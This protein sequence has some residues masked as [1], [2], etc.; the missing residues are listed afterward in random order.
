M[1][2]YKDLISFEPIE[3]VIQLREANNKEKA[4]SLLESYVISD[5]M[6]NRI[7]EDIFENL[8]FDRLVDNRGLL[9]VGNYGSG[10]SHLMSVVSTIAELPGSSKHLRHDEVAKK[11]EEV[12]GKFNV[13][14]AEFGAVTMPLRDIIC[15]HLERGLDKMGVEYIFPPSDQVTN[16]KDMLYEMMELFQ[17][18]YPEQGLLLVIDELLDYLRGRN[19]MQLTLDLGFL[20]ELGEVCSNSRFRFISGVQ[21]M[22]FDN[23]KFSFVAESLRRVKERFKETR[24]IREDIAFVVSERL[25]HKNEEQKAIIRDHLNKFTKMYNGLSEELDRY[26]DI[27]PIHP[28]YLEIFERVNI[29][30][31]RVALKTISEEIKK[32]ID[33]E[34]P[35]NETGFVSFDNY[36]E[37]I[38]EDA[39]LRSNDRVKVVMDKVTT[40]KGTIQ[41]SMKPVYKPM[42]EKMVNALAVFRLTTE[43]LNTPIG[44]SSEAMRDQL[45]ISN[46]SLL[47]LDD[48]IADFLKTTIDAAMKDL[49]NAASFQFISVNEAN[50]QYYINIDEAIPVD[51]LIN[52]RGDML[53]NAT[54]DSYYFDVLKN[55]TEVSDNTYVQGYKIWLH[56]I[57]W[58]DH[59]VKRQGYLFFGAPNER[60]TAQPERDFYIF[61]LQAFEEPKYKD[62]EREDEVFFRL[63]N[64][65]DKFVQLLRQYGGAVELYH[66]TTTNKSLYRPKITQYQK[67][68]LKWI[69]ERFADSFEVVYGGR[70]SM[71]ME[72][73]ALLHGDTDT[74]VDLID[75]VSQDLL[76]QWFGK[77]YPDYPRFGK[78]DRSYL[79]NSNLDIYAK[80]AL[81]YLNGKKTAQGEA[82]LNG[83]VLLDQQNK[84]AVQ[85]SGYAKWILDVLNK[86]TSTQVVNQN[87]LI[88]TINTVQG[89]VDQR[90]TKEFYLEPELLAVL[91]GALIHAGEI[92]VN[93]NGNTYDA[94]SYSEFSKLSVKDITHFNHIKK[95]TGLPIPEM[96]AL[97]EM[98]D[99]L[100]ADFSDS[101]QVDIMIANIISKAREKTKQV[102]ELLANLEE[103]L[104]KWDGPLYTDEELDDYVVQ[105]SSLN[106]FLQ[107]LQVYNTKAK[108]KNLK[109]TIERIEKEKEHLL[110]IDEIEQIHKK[111]IDYSKLADYLTKAQ[112]II[113]PDDKWKEK[114][115]NGLNQLSNSLRGNKDCSE[116][117]AELNHLK[118]QYINL[119][120]KLHQTNR[121]N[122]SASRKKNELLQSDKYDAVKVLSTKIKL[123]QNTSIFDEWREKVQSLKEC[124]TL[125]QEKLKHTPDCPDCRFNPKEEHKNRYSLEELEEALDS[126]LSKWT[127]TLVS[128]LNNTLIKESIDLLEKSQKDSIYSLIDQGEF[129]L[130]ISIDLID[131]INLVLEGIYQEKIEA[132]KL[133]EVLGNGNPI[134]VGEAREN[135]DRLLN[136]LVGLNDEGHVRLS[137]ESRRRNI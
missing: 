20:R 16:N 66:S 126:I 44:L 36:W 19:E 1:Y 7:T 33:E 83:L 111:L 100:R 49:R 42:A 98:F 103:R 121:L 134:T 26:V 6:A 129:S 18:K 101:N 99:A 72:Y 70:H 4:I 40:L 46:P 88:E 30:E 17:E 24:I 118:N 110:V 108:M 122:V 74:L 124:H 35:E 132:E 79:T 116:E 135:F 57:P 52:Q 133:V 97:S 91:L 59:R 13:I 114:V 27:F 106:S 96:R 81:N 48:D 75:N 113:S 85:K 87:E 54:L 61:M 47:D 119:Y 67:N 22:L 29:A 58:E 84:L 71:V 45:F 73:G 14:R 78:I 89:T 5:H 15:Q 11:A 25:L 53:D 130:P 9:I 80:D 56:E 34:L 60:S 77:K 102:T 50:G 51:E 38:L 28:A 125:T 64:K 69:K 39:S 23:P 107:D 117:V 37:H 112:L 123:F 128:N 76:S 105:L 131:A 95:P 10:K 41:T 8:Q 92:V 82:L 63:K 43:D 65:D 120:F 104:Q 12:E 3:S 31:K 2:Q 137:I 93:V 127:E 68:L 136:D 90:R 32:L 94:L 62:E 109:F 55:A 115:D 86:K 21:E